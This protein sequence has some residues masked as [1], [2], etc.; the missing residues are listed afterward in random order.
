MQ[1]ILADLLH[2]L[3]L[4][5]IETNIFRGESRDLGGARVFG[6]QVLGQALTAASYTVDG[7]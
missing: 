6:G 2:L 3:E 7:R 1:A 5:R 4:E